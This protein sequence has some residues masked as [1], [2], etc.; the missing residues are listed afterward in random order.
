M[1]HLMITWKPTKINSQDCRKFGLVY[2]LLPLDTTVN[3]P[4]WVNVM[5]IADSVTGTAAFF[6]HPALLCAG[7][8]DVGL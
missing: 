5:H 1:N 6:V 8:S 4:V 2:Y 7:I 3:F